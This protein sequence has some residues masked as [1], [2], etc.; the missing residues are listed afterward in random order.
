LTVVG[1]ARDSM[2]GAIWREKE[3]AVYVPAMASSDPRHLR[4]LVRTTTDP[5]AT[6]AGLRQIAASLD[7]DMRFVAYP[8]EELLRLWILPSRVAAAAAGVLGVIALALASIGIYGVL[9]YLV[10]QRTREIGI[11]MALGA[12]GADVLRLVLADGSRLIATGLFLGAVAAAVGAPLLRMLL[13]DVSPSD[14]LA[15]A[16]ALL[17]LTAVAICACYIPA[18]RAARLQP[19]TALRIE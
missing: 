9:A 1:L 4:L 5:A 2:T 14:P 11:R 17:I 7:P 18:R 12:G 13:F 16:A 6:A 15:F 10:S 19:L 3:L 8:L